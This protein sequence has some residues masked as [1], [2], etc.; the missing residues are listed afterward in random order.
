M[1]ESLPQTLH[2]KFLLLFF[3]AFNSNNIEF[4]IYFLVYLLCLPS[5]LDSN[6]LE[7]NGSFSFFDSRLHP[8]Y[9]TECLFAL[10]ALWL[11]LSKRSLNELK[12]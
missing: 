8:P 2:L 6:F 11:I 5:L 7:I 10:F 12:E 1:I 3:T 9:P 4:Y